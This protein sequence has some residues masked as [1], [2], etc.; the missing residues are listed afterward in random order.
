V[1][2]DTTVYDF[3]AVPHGAS[4]KTKFHFTNIGEDPLE[5]TNIR[6][7]CGCTAAEP[8]SRHLAPG[9]SADIEVTFDSS[10]KASPP[11]GRQHYANTIFFRT[12]DGKE[13]DGAPGTTKLTIQGD[14]VARYQIKPENGLFFPSF[15]QGAAAPV[16]ATVEVL[17]STEALPGQSPAPPLV[18]A[19]AGPGK[20]T[21]APPGVEVRGVR[22]IEKDGRRGIAIDVAVRPD[23]PVGMFDGQLHLATG[24]PAQPEVLVAVRGVIQPAAQAVP[25]RLLMPREPTGPTHTVRIQS[26]A[27]V[28]ILAIEVATA[29]GSPAPLE[30]RPTTASATIAVHAVATPDPTRGGAGDILIFLSSVRHPL[31]R[32]PYTLRE[33]AQGPG[34]LAAEKASGVRLSPPELFMGD[35]EPGK[36][37]DAAL[38]VIHSGGGPIAVTEVAAAPDGILDLRVDPVKPGE[39]ARLVARAKTGLKPGPFDVRIA[40]KPRPGSRELSA[41]AIGRVLPRVACEPAAAECVGAAPAT[42]AVTRVDGAPLRILEA[43]DP[44]GRVDVKLLDGGKLAVTP[45]APATALARTDILLKTDCAGEEE[46][47]LPVL[48]RP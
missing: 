44:A 48:L 4:V 7:S 22:A 13:R 38:L 32:V 45:R 33:V 24:D 47:K 27:P 10:H 8:T 34:E 39:V 46:V 30:A 28:E 25:P 2:F 20:V 31:I 43:R 41:R 36:E 17:P 23:A 16:T 19:P 42:V 11:H 1:K 37:R 35:V 9:Q 15:A 18:P 5:V 21:S 29:D 14:I 6:T 40:L 3:G 12:N 26:S